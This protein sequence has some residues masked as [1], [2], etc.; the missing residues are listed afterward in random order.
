MGIP[1]LEKKG[2]GM[3]MIPIPEIPIPFCGI[4][5]FRYLSYPLLE[6]A[7]ASLVLSTDA[8]V[9]N[10]VKTTETVPAKYRYV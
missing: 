10:I 3:G 7:Y 6:K 5:L 2:D 9:R 1:K 8:I 4:T